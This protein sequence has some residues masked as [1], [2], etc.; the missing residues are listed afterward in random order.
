MRYAPRMQ[1]S[2]VGPG[3]EGR[4]SPD[5]VYRVRVWSRSNQSSAE[6]L[7]EYR[8]RGSQ[9]VREVL[10]WADGH[11]P[12]GGRWEVLIECDVIEE[13][14]SGFERGVEMYRVAG[15][16][17]EHSLGSIVMFEPDGPLVHKV[18]RTH[19]A[20]EIRCPTIRTWPPV[21]RKKE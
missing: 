19:R 2:E 7:T 12:A 13:T 18:G 20:G 11:A 3:N 10:R 8:V 6:D 17:A 21:K 16:P 4:I 5:T 14:S 1:V 9:D 15:L